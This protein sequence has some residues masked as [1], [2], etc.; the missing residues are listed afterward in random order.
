MS[1]ALEKAILISRAHS[2]STVRSKYLQINTD[3]FKNSFINRLDLKY[4]YQ[5]IEKDIVQSVTQAVGVCLCRTMISQLLQVKAGSG[6]RAAVVLSCRRRSLLSSHC[7]FL[8][9]SLLCAPVLTNCCDL[10]PWL[11]GKTFRVCPT[12]VE[13]MTFRT[14]YH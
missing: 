7:S 5:S 14:L 1:T 3:T 11:L 8:F 9:W 10:L 2:A 12:G 6:G 4:N 13:P